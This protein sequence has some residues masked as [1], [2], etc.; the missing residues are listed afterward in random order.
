MYTLSKMASAYDSQRQK[1]VVKITL[2]RPYN[3]IKGP[4]V[5]FVGAYDTM[6]EAKAA[7]DAAVLIRDEVAKD[8]RNYL[9]SQKKSS[10][11]KVS[12]SDS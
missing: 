6:S 11:E 7:S 12:V 3:S 8:F 1:Y 4:N 2:P 5:K 10:L 9:Q